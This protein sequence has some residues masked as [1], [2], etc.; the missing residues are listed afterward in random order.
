MTGREVC[1]WLGATHT[2]LSAET[3]HQVK[4]ENTL[5]QDYEPKVR[6]DGQ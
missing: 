3:I 4:E 2:T 1:T 5:F 6:E